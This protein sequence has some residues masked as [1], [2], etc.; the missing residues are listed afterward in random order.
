[1]GGTGTV[2]HVG[3][4]GWGTSFVEVVSSSDKECN[5]R[6]IPIRNYFGR[7]LPQ[8]TNSSGGMFEW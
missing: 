7:P 8:G 6:K 4:K 1:V 5:Y 2:G 3:E